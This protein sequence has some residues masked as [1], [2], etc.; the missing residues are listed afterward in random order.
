MANLFKSTKNSDTVLNDLIR[1]ML[2]E[3]SEHSI[4]N[5]AEIYKFKNYKISYSLFHC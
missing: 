3:V 5:S 2:D 4:N 1:I